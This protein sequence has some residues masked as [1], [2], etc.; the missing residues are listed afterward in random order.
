MLGKSRRGT[1]AET[2]TGSP[3]AVAFDAVNGSLVDVTAGNQA[4][5]PSAPILPV[6]YTPGPSR[7]TWNQHMLQS[8]VSACRKEG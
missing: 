4:K 3:D 1:Y 5:Y 2:G 7:R 8:Q 6:K